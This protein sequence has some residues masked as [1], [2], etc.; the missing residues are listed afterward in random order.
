MEY[1][2]MGL[3]PATYDYSLK[4]RLDTSTS[5]ATE[6]ETVIKS[7]KATIRCLVPERTQE[8]CGICSLP[9]ES[10]IIVARAY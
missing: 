3:S 8:L 6:C 4:A 7:H 10:D 1:V 5:D 2:N 9:S